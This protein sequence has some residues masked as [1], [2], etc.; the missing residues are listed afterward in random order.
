MKLERARAAGELARPSPQRLELS[1][2]P[3]AVAPG[4]VRRSTV[5]MP[6]RS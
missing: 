1:A 3:Q 4:S 6:T 5:R 2:H